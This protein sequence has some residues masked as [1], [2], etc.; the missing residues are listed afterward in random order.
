MFLNGYIQTP[1]IHHFKG[2]AIK[3]LQYK[4]KKMLKSH[5]KGRRTDSIYYEFLRYRRYD[6]QHLNFVKYFHL[7]G[8]KT[9]QTQKLSFSFRI[10]VYITSRK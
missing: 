8:K 1:N 5:N 4:M 7:V 9:G 6:C 2:F 10:T 3:I